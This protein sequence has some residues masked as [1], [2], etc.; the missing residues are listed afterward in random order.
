MTTTPRIPAPARWA[1]LA[2]HAVALLTLPTGLWRLLPAAGR[3]AGYTE[4]GLRGDGR[5]RTGRGV[6]W[7]D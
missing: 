1:V 4:G 7:W 2:A 3:P 6:R 5:R